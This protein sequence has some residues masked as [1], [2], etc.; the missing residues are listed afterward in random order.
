[1]KE[2]LRPPEVRAEPEQN[3]CAWCNNK[4]RQECYTECRGYS[5]LEPVPMEQWEFGPAIP[6]YKE[7]QEWSA[8]EVRA[9]YF[10]MFYYLK[11]MAM[12]GSIR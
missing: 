8:S 9:F 2:R 7:I 10:L 4:G 1:M 3:I 11:E 5:F 12:R 6:S